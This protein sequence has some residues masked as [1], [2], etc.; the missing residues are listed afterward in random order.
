MLTKK[1]ILSSSK[2]QYTGYTDNQ[3]QIKI[4]YNGDQSSAPWL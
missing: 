4:I 3:K 1:E 2:V